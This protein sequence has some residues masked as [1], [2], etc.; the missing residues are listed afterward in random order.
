MPFLTRL[1]FD[2][3]GYQQSSLNNASMRLAVFIEFSGG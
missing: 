3:C 2:D 1:F